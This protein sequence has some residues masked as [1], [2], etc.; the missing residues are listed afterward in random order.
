MYGLKKCVP[1]HIFLI[2]KTFVRN[3][4]NFWKGNKQ[5]KKKKK[6]ERKQWL[7]QNFHVLNHTQAQLS[8]MS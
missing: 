3:Q 5:S 1:S 8:G 6:K 2:S 4:T 7:T